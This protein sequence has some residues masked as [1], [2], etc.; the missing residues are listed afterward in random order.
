[1]TH[2]TKPPVKVR[3]TVRLR[4]YDVIAAAIEGAGTEAIRR[5]LK[6]RDFELPRDIDAAIATEVEHAVMSR[7]CEVLDF[8][9]P[10]RPVEDGLE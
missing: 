2:K 1:M 5:A 8:G 4:A 9:D 3:A 7:L 6:H 10:P